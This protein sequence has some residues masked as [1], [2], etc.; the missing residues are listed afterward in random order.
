[1]TQ[2]LQPSGWAA[3]G[4]EVERETIALPRSPIGLRIVAR[5]D[6]DEIVLNGRYAVERCSASGVR[7]LLVSIRTA[8][9]ELVRTP[10][11]ALSDAGGH[12]TLEPS[13]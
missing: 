4:L 12:L 1:M 7:D 5:D 11:L 10:E 13:R 8:M 3:S 9:D 2:I 6:G